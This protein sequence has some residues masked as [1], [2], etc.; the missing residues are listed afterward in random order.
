MASPLIVANCSGFYGDRLSAMR[1]QLDGG[2][3]DVICGD[4]LAE[5]TMLIL[6]RQKAKDASAG[7]ARSFVRQL[8]DCLADALERGVRIVSNAGGL[9]PAGLADAVRE[10]AARLGLSV[11]VATVAGDDL[12]ES[13]ESLVAK[14]RLVG[15]EAPPRDGVAAPDAGSVPLTANAYLGSAGIV[16]ALQA[17]AQVVVTGRVTDASLVAGPAMWH[18]GWTSGDLDALAGATV[19]G[20]LLECGAQTTGG[21]FSLYADLL[22]APGADSGM[23]DHVAFPLAEVAEDGSCVITKHPGTGGAVTVATVTEQLLYECTGIAYGGPDVVSRFDTVTLAQEGPDRVSVAGVRG[24]PAGPWLKVSTNRIGGFRT[25]MTVPLTGLD[26]ERKAELL[27]RQ[28]A[29]ALDAAAEVTVTLARTDRTDAG[30]AEQASALLHF[31]VKDS[32]PAKVGRAFS[33]PVVASALS[34]IPGFFVTSPPSDAAPFGVYAPAWVRRDDVQELVD[35]E[36]IAA[37][38]RP[39]V[40]PPVPGPAPRRAF[41]LTAATRRVPLGVLA[42]ARSGDKGGSCTLGV[43]TRTDAAYAWLAEYLTCERLQELLPEAATLDVTREELANVRAVLFQI[44][45]LL[46]QGVAAATRFDPQAK[47]VG[48][49]LRSRHVDAPLTLLDDPASLGSGRPVEGRE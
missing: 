26:I 34:S 33:G 43:Y 45:G 20:H 22:D 8:E 21:N 40:S 44:P 23:L 37:P 19:C 12:I 38:A 2:P 42:G 32:D 17:G 47:A 46:G 15:G 4:Y 28:L 6:G 31:T 1:E 35:G 10:L 24:E 36:V 14:G 9:N 13:W 48:E 3:V 5:L 29:D 25:S 30:T 41:D 49:W 39:T 11:R 7:Y 27:Q 16:R 18:H